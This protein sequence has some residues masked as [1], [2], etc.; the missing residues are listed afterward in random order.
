MPDTQETPLASLVAQAQE[1]G[2]IS[3]A[4][5]EAILA[6]QLEQGSPSAQRLEAPRGFNAVTVAYVL[7]AMLV[8]FAF[9]WLLIDRW[10]TLGPAGV[11]G[12]TLGYVGLLWGCARWLA[13]RDYRLAA[14]VA[15]MLA[16]SLLPIVTWSLLS[17]AGV[18]P[19]T[20]TG[21]DPFATGDRAATLRWLLV[22]LTALIAAAAALRRRPHV[23]LTIPATVALWAFLMHV[24]RLIGGPWIF[25]RMDQWLFLTSGL[26]VCAVAGEVDRWQ[27]TRRAVGRTAQGDYA[28]FPWLGGLLAFSVAYVGIWVRADGWKHLLPLVGGI[29]ILMALLLHRRTHLVFGLMAVCG[30]LAYLAAEVF[31]DYLSL[32]A[33]L[34]SG[35]I[36]LILLTV[37]V[38]RRFPSVVE[39]LDRRRQGTPLPPMVT[40]G[41]FLLALGMSLL[42]IPDAKEARAQED[43]RRELTRMRRHNDSL[44]AQHRPGDS[45]ITRPG[46]SEPHRP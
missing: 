29:L 34:A 15:L 19:S 8:V 39:R 25:S 20:D 7:G 14:G 21:G 31:R 22:D 28:F 42:T 2:I 11:M 10:Q 18:W 9:G 45:A 23:A 5:G 32:P 30:Y 35:G 43:F 46:R 12:V 17:I 37:W 4:Q 41:P 1:R 3:A 27:A 38:Q 6:L 16:V 24:T 13:R 36:L 44:R 40:R 26:G 33:V